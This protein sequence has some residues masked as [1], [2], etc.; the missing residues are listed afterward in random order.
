VCSSIAARFA[1]QTRVGRSPAMQKL[2]SA[3]FVREK[4]RRVTT[5]G[6]RCFGHCFSK[7]WPPST[8]FG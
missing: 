8:P 7:K 3:S 4:T 5:H 2:M 1:S 6:G